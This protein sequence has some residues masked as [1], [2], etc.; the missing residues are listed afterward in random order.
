MYGREG[1]ERER[2][3]ESGGKRERE[4]KCWAREKECSVREREGETRRGGIEW[5]ERR[6]RKRE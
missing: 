2:L 6:E 5:G 3:R 1:G 4:R